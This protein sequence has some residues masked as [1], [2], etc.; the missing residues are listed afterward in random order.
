MTQFLV[1]ALGSYGDVHPMAGP[2]SALVARGHR[3]KLIT[4]P[5]FADVVA[6]T[7]AELISLGTSEEYATL[8]RTSRSLASAARSQ[9]GAVPRCRVVLRPLYEASLRITPGETVFCAHALDLAS[10]VACEKL[11]APLASVVLAPGYYGLFTIHHVSKVV[12]GTHVPRWLKPANFG[13]PIGFLCCR[14]SVLRSTS[15]ASSSAFRLSNASSTAGCTKPTCPRSV[16]RLVRPVTAGLATQHAHRRFSTL[17]FDD[18]KRRCRRSERIPCRRHPAHR[19]FARLRKSPGTPILHRRRR[20]LPTPRP[21]RHLAHQIRPPTP[22]EL[23]RHGPP[24]RLRPAQQTVASHGRARPPRR[25]RQLRPRL[26]RRHPANRAAVVLRPVR[27]FPA[28]RRTRRRPRNLRP[29]L[30]RP[31]N[32]QIS[33]HTFLFADRRHSLPRPSLPLQRPRRPRRRLHR[34]R[35]TGQIA[36]RAL[37]VLIGGGF[38]RPHSAIRNPQSAIPRSHAMSHDLPLADLRLLMFVGD[39]YE[40]LELWYPKLTSRRGRCPRHRRWPEG[41]NRLSRQARLPLSLGC[42]DRPHGVRRLP[43][44]RDPRRLHAR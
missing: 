9:I 12:L 34:P 39:D 27:Q 10:R 15:C 41:R 21:P 40:D 20:R 25:H 7:G 3:V 1:T 6:G 28:T 23:T 37:E 16:P 14:Y 33:R 18:W 2:A 24:L 8:F 32:C 35:T 38:S 29:S 11:A 13:Q 44:R 31:H 42:C 30:R 43:R 26:C 5:Y 19:L 36:R 4:S 22:A 17:G